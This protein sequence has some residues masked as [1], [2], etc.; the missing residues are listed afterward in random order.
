M[1]YM[2][3]QHIN[4]VSVVTGSFELLLQLAMSTPASAGGTLFEPVITRTAASRRHAKWK[5]A[6]QR[7]FRLAELTDDLECDRE[8]REEAGE[9]G[10]AGEGETTEVAEPAG[11]VGA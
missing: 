1:S 10:E 9:A 6:V 11:E 2:T 7:S 8:Q 5:L 4:N 3:D